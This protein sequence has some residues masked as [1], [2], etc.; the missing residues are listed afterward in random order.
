MLGGT[1]SDAVH[2]DGAGLNGYL[3][4]L[5]DSTV[6]IGI[7]G[8]IIG[9]QA[10]GIARLTATTGSSAVKATNLAS[11]RITGFDLT[12][13]AGANGG[14]NEPGAVSPAVISL[15]NSNATIQQVVLRVGK[16]VTAAKARE[17][18]TAAK[19][20]REATVFLQTTVA[21]LSWSIAPSPQE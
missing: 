16:A 4:T 19:G 21:R 11:F 12:G 10:D 7:N 5:L 6:P 18:T 14:A 2:F 20:A 17:R 1:Y 9:G 13:S 15:S 3:V 8:Q